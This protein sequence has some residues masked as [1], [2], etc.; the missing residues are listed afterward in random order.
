MKMVNKI[1]SHKEIVSTF[2]TRSKL[3]A[4]LGFLEKMPSKLK[5]EQLS[6]GA[7]SSSVS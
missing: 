3:I 5:K 6:P 4:F 1:H 2:R 7:G